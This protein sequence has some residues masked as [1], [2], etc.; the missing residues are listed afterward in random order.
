MKKGK[1]IKGIGGFYYVEADNVVYECKARG[2]F[3]KQGKTPLVGDDVMISIN[4]D[5][6]VD[7][8]IEEILDRKN[9]LVRPPLANLDTLFIVASLV[10]P[11]INTQ[12]IDKL[13][14][15]AEF[16]G[17]EPVLVLTKVD[18]EPNYQEYVDIYT[19]A[20]FKV[21]VCD[22]EK[23]IGA[24]E[25]KNL[26][27]GKISAFTGNTGVGK[28]SLLNNICPELQLATG[29]TSKKL[30][31]GKHTTRHSE[32]FKACGGYIADTPG[33]SSLDFER[34]EKIMKEDLPYC[35]REFEPYLEDCKFATSC[36][37]VNDKGCAV[38][39]AVE[40]GKIS[41]SRH[42]SYVSMYNDVK[43]IKQWQMK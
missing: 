7:N 43:D 12:I 32:L 36:S 26:L 30:G 16:K 41:K 28:S 23:G 8:A 29:E 4:E 18:L 34:C 17:I 14:A 39:K 33:F 27:K 9:D 22:N 38:C 6:N 25:V 1:I 37:H 24:D 40:D 10:D 2:S 20:G 21:V 5:N 11:K 31:R 13:I 19:S 3:R 15:I 42:N 35:F